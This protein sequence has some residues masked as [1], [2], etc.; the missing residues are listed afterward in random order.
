MCL[1]KMMRLFRKRKLAVTEADLELPKVKPP[2]KWWQFPVRLIKTKRPGPN[3]PKYYFCPQCRARS[4]RL[5]KTMGGANYF[6]RNHGRFF[7]RS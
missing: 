7:V 3:M 5:D 4:K 1:S 2:R 6:C